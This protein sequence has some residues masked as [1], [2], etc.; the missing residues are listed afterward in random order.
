MNYGRVTDY[1]TNLFPKGGEIV[2]QFLALVGTTIGIIRRDRLAI[3]LGVSCI[4][5]AGCFM[6]LPAGIAWNPRWLPFW[7]LFT[8]L[9]AAYAVSELGTY[10]FSLLHQPWLSPWVTAAVGSALSV[11]IVA[12]Y[13]GVLPFF[14]TP[15]SMLTPVKSWVAWNYTGYQARAGWPEFSRI[16]T[17]LDKAGAKYGCGRLDYEYTSNISDMGSNIVEMSFPLWTNGCMDSM[18]GIY[19]ESSTSTPFH[20]LDQAQLSVQ[21]SNPSPGLPYQSLNVV[22]GVAHLQLEGVNYF[23]A[24]SRKV[25]AEANVDPMLV[26]IASTPENPTEEDGVGTSPTANPSGPTSWVLYRILSSQMVA[27]LTYQPVVESGLSKTSW[28][29]LG[30]EWYQASADWAVPI[31]ES[32]PASWRRVRSSQ[33]V[34]PSDGTKLPA[35][36]VS[37]I[38]MTDSTVTFHV[39]RVGVPVL[40][41]VPY[42]P[43]WHS[44]G[45]A[46][47]VEVTPNDMVVVPTSTVVTLTYGTTAVDWAGRAATLFGLTALV[48][49]WHPADVSAP[50]SEASPD[51]PGGGSSRPD[52]APTGGPNGAA[53]VESPDPDEWN[54]DDD[55]DDPSSDGDREMQP[56][57]R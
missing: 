31:A 24:N 12:A 14:K 13:A 21:P 56:T 50:T 20:F 51:S 55:Q 10:I 3:T 43:N 54:G 1:F 46:A 2:I 23:L 28:L 41:K 8:A 38:K 11:C 4:G 30:I 25:E 26:R 17:M 22:E 15:P 45:A 16:V 42:F 5:A 39:S 52:G 19:F 37:D 57:S 6:V 29:S 18:E 27:P 44:A 7:F 35:V 49:L 34:K 32:G 53:I 9:T 40:V 36:H 47:P 48:G 33:I